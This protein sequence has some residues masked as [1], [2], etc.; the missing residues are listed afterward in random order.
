MAGFDK[1]GGRGG[2][3]CPDIIATQWSQC[4]NARGGHSDGG[5][6]G[7]VGVI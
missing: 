3:G 6:G 4:N 7:R 2:E 5:G 1:M